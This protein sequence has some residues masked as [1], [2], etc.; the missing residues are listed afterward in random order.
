MLRQKDIK[1]L[2]EELLSRKAE[3]LSQTSSSKT[4]IKNLLSEDTF[5]TMDYAEV[6][7]DSHNLNVLREKQI[8]EINDIDRALAKIENNTY[9][10]CEMCDEKIGIKRLR[11][12]PHAIYCVECRPIYEESLKKRKERT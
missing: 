10:T 8:K 12:K 11:A 4:I 1:I 2:K 9:G 5:D 7:S 3:L 6:A